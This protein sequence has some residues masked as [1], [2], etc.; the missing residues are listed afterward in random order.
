MAVSLTQLLLDAP[1]M[2]SVRELRSRGI[3]QGPVLRHGTLVGGDEIRFTHHLLHDYAIARSLI[4][5]TPMPFC[6]FAVS[7]PFLPVFYRQSF[8][9]ALE[10]IWDGPNGREGFWES[11]LRLEGVAK[12][13]GL[14]RILAPVLAARRVET[15]PD[16]Q[17]L[18]A[19]VGSATNAGSPGHKALLHLASA[20][21][22]VDPDL[23]RTGAAGWCAFVEQLTGLLPAKPFIEW[24]L[25]HILARLNAVNIANDPSQRLALS[26]AG[27]RL[28]AHHVSRNVAEER[29]YPGRTAIETICRTFTT[30]PAESE[31]AL[32]S[33]LAPARL[34]QFP[35]ST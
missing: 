21:Q 28:L 2:D 7:D 11:A 24:P 15:L 34:A 9:F 30:A 29:Q 12:L 33:L 8:L 20:L 26:A 17:P 27:R 35:H 3:L 16:L 22:D 23:I 4:P 32:L 25:V 13:H 10:E 18:L 6:D 14:T 31:R 1:A 19:A 5:G